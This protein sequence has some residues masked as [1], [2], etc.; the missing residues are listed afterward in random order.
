MIFNRQQLRIVCV[1]YSS[2]K[3]CQGKVFRQRSRVQRW[4]LLGLRRWRKIEAWAACSGPWHSRLAQWQFCWQYWQHRKPERGGDE[5]LSVDHAAAPCRRV[6][7]CRLAAPPRCSASSVGWC[8]KPSRRWCG[9]W[10]LRG[11]WAPHA[12]GSAHS[13]TGRADSPRWDGLRGGGWCVGS[14]FQKCYGFF[15]WRNI[16]WRN[17]LWLLG[18]LS[19]EWCP[20]VLYQ[21]YLYLGRL[22]TCW[23]V[24]WPADLCKSRNY[25]KCSG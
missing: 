14:P 1:W 11:A 10:S 5:F 20:V 23:P 19:C 17:E 8:V 12:G 6:L 4:T 16:C 13:G 15:C 25:L 3:W 24:S 7:A 18:S 21:D 2:L 22:A 9:S